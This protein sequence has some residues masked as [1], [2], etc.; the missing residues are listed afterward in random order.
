MGTLVL[1]AT[2]MDSEQIMK[3]VNKS[4][5]LSSSCLAGQACFSLSPSLEN[6]HQYVC[7]VL[8]C[9]VLFGT[10]R[11]STGPDLTRCMDVWMYVRV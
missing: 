4:T 9:T 5:V 8:Y 1:V 6:I 3:P 2:K 11:Y 10:V 7:N